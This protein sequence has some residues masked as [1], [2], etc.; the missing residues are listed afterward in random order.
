MKPEGVTRVEMNGRDYISI[1]GD[2]GSYLKLDYADI[3]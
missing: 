2:G 1:V 3:E